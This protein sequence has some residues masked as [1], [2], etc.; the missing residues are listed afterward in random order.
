MVEG[1][2]HASTKPFSPLALRLLCGRFRGSCRGFEQLP[3]DSEL[4]LPLPSCSGGPPVVVYT[5]PWSGNGLRLSPVSPHV[6]EQLMGASCGSRAWRVALMCSLLFVKSWLRFTW[7]SWLLSSSA[8][9]V[10]Y[11]GAQVNI[12]RLIAGQISLAL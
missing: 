9:Y 8:P 5:C 6:R 7:C 12:S 1:G 2:P 10:L 11:T 3:T 4:L